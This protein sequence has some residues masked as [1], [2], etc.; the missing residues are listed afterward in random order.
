[1]RV[2][3]RLMMNYGHT[4]LD[5]EQQA[6]R[7][8]VQHLTQANTHLKNELQEMKDF[9][10]DYGLQWVGG[11][12]S[13]SSSSKAESQVLQSKAESIAQAPELETFDFDV[14]LVLRRIEELN[15]LA[16]AGSLKITEVSSNV[17]RFS[18]DH[19]SLSLA[20][21]ADGFLLCRGPFRVYAENESARAFIQDLLDGYYPHE[22]K[23]RYPEGV[24]FDVTDHRASR[25]RT[26]L[27]A[28]A[29][30]ATT[31]AAAADLCQQLPSCVI[32][33]GQ[34]IP[35]RESVESCLG[36]S[37]TNSSTDRTMS[38]STTG[39]P[40]QSTDDPALV[41][42]IRSETGEHTEKLVVSRDTTVV[43]ELYTR[44][45]LDPKAFELR[46]T[47]P[48]RVYQELDVTL[49]EAGLHASATL[50]SK[51]RWSS[52]TGLLNTK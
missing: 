17:H 2:L 21:Y 34:I 13:R 26:S 47:F 37:H 43:R 14:D 8:Q 18:Q 46:S 36:L 41:F 51:A 45:N 1:M 31:E 5:R 32:R 20:L 48:T 12:G 7:D 6:A 25:Y 30:R 16:G 19:T 11:G 4:H 23:D 15:V 10:Q 50:F 33:K 38:K 44:L 9:L 24:I 39:K 3:L 40:H 35:I 28:S 29:G 27:V 52:S 22:F 49:A 42:H